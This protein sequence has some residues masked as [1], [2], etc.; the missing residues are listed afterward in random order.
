MKQENTAVKEVVFYRV[1]TPDTFAD[2]CAN[3][4]NEVKELRKE[5]GTNDPKSEYFENAK[6][7]RSQCYIEKVTEISERV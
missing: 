4:L 3:T 1:V 5:F 6:E 7:I 2:L